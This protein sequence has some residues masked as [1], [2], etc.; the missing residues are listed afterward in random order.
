MRAGDKV[1]RR[2]VSVLSQLYMERRESESIEV[3]IRRLN[4]CVGMRRAKERLCIKNIN[5]NKNQFNQIIGRS[6]A[7]NPCEHFLKC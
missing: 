4:L 1:N 5:K 6:S 7:N 2:Y 3:T